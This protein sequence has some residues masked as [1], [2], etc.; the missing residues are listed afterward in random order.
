MGSVLLRIGVLYRCPS[1][2]STA[3]QMLGTWRAF[4][5]TFQA[6]NRDWNEKQQLSK[7]QI[8]AARGEVK[9]AS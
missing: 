2:R 9:A 5:D 8:D 3:S 6:F 7:A 1:V 4:V